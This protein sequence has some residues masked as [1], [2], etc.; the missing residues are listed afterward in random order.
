MFCTVGSDITKIKETISNGIARI[1][2][3][4]VKQLYFMKVILINFNYEGKFN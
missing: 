2:I 1:K 3:M 4:Y